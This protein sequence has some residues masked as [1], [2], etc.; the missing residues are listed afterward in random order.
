MAACAIVILQREQSLS[1]K[2][3]CNPPQMGRQDPRCP[4]QSQ[5]LQPSLLTSRVQASQRQ[6]R[7]ELVRVSV[8]NVEMLFVI[9]LR[10]TTGR[11]HPAPHTGYVM[12]IG[13]AV[14]RHKA[15]VSASSLRTCHSTTAG[16]VCSSKG[17]SAL[18]RP[19]LTHPV[20]SCL[21]DEPGRAVLPHVHLA[22]GAAF[23]A[24]TLPITTDK[25]QV[26]DWCL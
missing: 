15:F 24:L 7:L 12:P 9:L 5:H 23:T 25:Q 10:N 21:L 13:L 11:L 17:Y 8:Q 19:S 26:F 3:S 18:H 16:P 4:T 22:L 20:T 6:S 1:R 2:Q 14:Q